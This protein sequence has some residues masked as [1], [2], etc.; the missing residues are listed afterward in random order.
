[1]VSK[2]MPDRSAPQVGIGCRSNSFSALSRRS[3]IHCGS[4]FFSEMSRTTSSSTPRRAEAPA[5]SLSDQ[6]KAYRPSVSMV[7]AWSIRLWLSGSAGAGGASTAAA[8][9]A[10]AVS[11]G[12]STPVAGVW[13]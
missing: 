7:A 11:I 4:L 12:V 6:P 1:M 2:W 3:S 5:T 10:R 9:G 13:S 8:T